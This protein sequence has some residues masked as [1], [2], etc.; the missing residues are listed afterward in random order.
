M[1]APEDFDPI[2][3]A[4]PVAR[5]SRQARVA[6]GSHVVT[7]GGGAPVRLQSMTNTDTVDAVG[8]AIQVKELAR[9]GSEVVRITVNTA[10]A[11]AAVPATSY[12]SSALNAVSSS[13]SSR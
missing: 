7:V 11:A 5:H 4:A 13:R 1:N 8:T 3:A 12:R 6:W 2:E 10:E 9:A